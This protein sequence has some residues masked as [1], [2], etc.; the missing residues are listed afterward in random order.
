MVFPVGVR[1]WCKDL[2][3]HRGAKIINEGRIMGE[4]IKEGIYVRRTSGLVR[5]LGLLATLAISMGGAIGAGIHVVVLQAAYQYPGA[6]VPLAYFLVGLMSLPLA[7]V[8]AYIAGDLP[9]SSSYY[10]FVSRN[11]HPLVGFVFAWG[12]ILSSAFVTG[13]VTRSFA[14]NL[15]PLLWL[16]GKAMKA[17]FLVDAS[18]FFMT[19]TGI[20][21]A[22]FVTLV[23]YLLVFTFG[24][25]VYGKFLSIVFLIPIISYI[26][27]IGV[28][29]LTP[30]A[31]VPALYDATWGEGAYQEILNLGAKYGYKPELYLPNLAAT[32]AVMSGAV[33]AYQGFDRAAYVA[34][35]VK[36]PRKTLMR[37]LFW[38]TVA[39]VIIYTAI[40]FFAYYLYGDWII[41]YNIAITKGAKEL[42]INPPVKSP[43]V[44]HLAASLLPNLPVLQIILYIGILIE[45]WNTPPTRWL[46]S[47]RTMFAMSFDRFLPEK[48]TYVHPKTGSP[49]VADTIAFLLSIVGVIFAH[50]YGIYA[51]AISSTLFDQFLLLFPFVG[52]ILYPFLR[53]DAYKSG[54]KYE[55]KG[56][57]VITLVGIPAL[58]IQILILLICVSTTAMT[59]LTFGALWWFIG[60]LVFV[61]YYYRNLKRGIDP[62]LI[63]GEI[64]PA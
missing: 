56:F 38:G 23:V 4:T 55:Y 22:C 53:E 57:P 13:T 39:L 3:E 29:A 24:A 41:N 58:A 20:L 17:P 64:P 21:L 25:K 28:F 37:G 52:A 15:G 30:P 33:F 27:L 1:F 10:V 50:Y 9:R 31:N 42:V 5:E 40:A 19:D 54:Y 18:S 59:A 32:F 44:A 34:G 36:A 46:I 51:A 47:S 8:L 6:N 63:F 49:I 35:E 61:Y 62:K 26:V 48:I 45:L 7:F 16:A 2:Y 60:A 43:F 12:V 11:V 14:V